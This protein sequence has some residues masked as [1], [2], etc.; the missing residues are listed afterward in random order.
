MR[1]LV[2]QFSSLLQLWLV[3]GPVE[4]QQLQ[5]LHKLCMEPVLLDSIES[6][7]EAGPRYNQLQTSL[8]ALQKSLNETLFEFVLH[9][10]KNLDSSA[11]TPRKLI[12]TVCRM[13]ELDEPSYANALL[14]ASVSRRSV[15]TRIATRSTEYLMHL[16]TSLGIPC[17]TYLGNAVA[18]LDQLPIKSRMEQQPMC[19]R[20]EPGAHHVARAVAD[21][22]A[23]YKWRRLCIIASKQTPG[24]QA[25]IESLKNLADDSHEMN[26]P[27]VFRFE[28]TQVLTFDGVA[29]VSDMRRCNQTGCIRAYDSVL[30]RLVSGDDR[31]FF[32]HGNFA[33]LRL[34]VH[35]V[36]I[37]NSR[38]GILFDKDYLW[39]VSP[40]AVTSPTS[41]LKS[42][43]DSNLGTIRIAGLFA[44]YYDSNLVKAVTVASQLWF[45]AL[46]QFKQRLLQ[47]SVAAGGSLTNL[48]ILR[49]MRP[50]FKCS[51]TTG[52]F[53]PDGKE[54]FRL[55]LNSSHCYECG[56]EDKRE[57]IGFDRRGLLNTTEFVLL[58]SRPNSLKDSTYWHPVGRWAMSSQHESLGGTSF[59]MQGVTW[60]G[61]ASQAPLG[62]P[63][64]FRLR[65]ATLKEDPFVRYRP[66][67]PPGSEACDPVSLPCRV[68][69]E[70]AS[71]PDRYNW[72][73][74]NQSESLPYTASCCSGLAIDLLREL[75]KDLNFEVD[76]FEVPDKK[77]GG[78]TN[79]EWNGLVRVLLEGQADMVVT[80]LKI[81]P[82]R[83]EQIE[84]SVPF[85][86]TGITIL[87]A[88][89]EGA[90]ST[91]AFL[92]PYDYPSWCLILVFS[93]HACGAALFLFEWLSPQ[94]LDKGNVP[95]REHKFSLFR[96]LWLIWSMLFG[97]AVNADNPRGVAS[98]FLGNIWALFALV[99]LASY[100][101]NLAAFMIAEES[102]YD[103]SGI[104][105][106][107]L[108]DPTSHRPPFRFATVPSGA[109]EENMRMNYPDIANHM[110]NYSK[111]NIDEGIRTLKTFEIDAFIYDATVLQYRVGNDEDCKLKTVG[112]WYSMTGYGIGLPKGSKWRHRIN[113]RIL[114]YRSSGLLERWSK[115]WIT[116][117]CQQSGKLRNTNQTLG[118]KNFIS[119]FILLIGGMLFCCLLLLLEHCFYRRL[120]PQLKKWDRY[121]CC[122]LVSIS[123]GQ[124]LSFEQSVNQTVDLIKHH[125][126]Q[127]PICETQ[128]WKLRHELDTTKRKLQRL[129]G[130]LN[131]RLQT[132]TSTSENETRA[133]TDSAPTT[134]GNNGQEYL[135]ITNCN[136]G[137]IAQK[138]LPLHEVAVS[139]RRD[140]NCA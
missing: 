43:F 118:V 104:N 4:S 107:R 30:R 51:N 126:C 121:G 120:R 50:T 16:L 102:Y 8:A 88:L 81:T 62:R 58:N 45:Q 82:N 83:S 106:W 26:D 108:R 13:L 125:K 69:A 73:A 128:L 112:N 39:I 103:L 44:L 90:I 14:I 76:L 84:F 65:A 139:E 6:M 41:D 92:K 136:Q 123:M 113:H 68:L 100:T 60:P 80:S 137:E 138:L 93:V 72:S 54:I 56:N 71:L 25:V 70:N 36:H 96:S 29:Q 9:D 35:R 48:D 122:G 15:H 52:L 86:R 12:R 91:K 17:F 77:W 117:A 98:R 134:I 49:R 89:R 87:V 20:L 57:Y 124:L 32:L 114:S 33:D 40:S 97:A 63:K 99:F 34:L 10:L 119:A 22:L 47:Q 127:N 28:V 42:G 109:T 131:G 94:G 67:E 31:I 59:D 105:D 53:W 23:I 46:R 140:S 111:S 1:S 61:L 37:K 78:W 5:F 95:P 74:G 66:P 18:Q 101:A 133:V 129:E 64:K 79:N 7:K 115:Y 27:N 24:W 11:Q 130:M 132:A 135:R 116:G 21:F 110:R 38:F 55:A 75:M 3:L 85:H 2:L 19:I